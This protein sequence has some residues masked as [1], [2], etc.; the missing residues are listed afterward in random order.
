MNKN[1]GK[2]TVNMDG[3]PFEFK[4]EVSELDPKKKV[5]SYMDENGIRRSANSIQEIQTNIANVFG[6]YVQNIEPA[7]QEVLNVIKKKLYKVK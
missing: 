1:Y 3:I 2:A 4:E 6:N 7:F 5:Y